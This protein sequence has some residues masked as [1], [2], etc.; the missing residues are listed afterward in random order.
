MNR[1]SA[2]VR[3]GLVAMEH[4]LSREEVG[5]VFASFWRSTNPNPSEETLLRALGK[6]W[7]KK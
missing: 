1:R 4:G 3:A 7:A 5:L 6:V 2:Y